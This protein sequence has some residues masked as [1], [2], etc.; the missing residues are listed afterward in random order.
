M[1]TGYPVIEQTD[2]QVDP[3]KMNDRD[4]SYSWRSSCFPSEPLTISL[5]E[6]KED[7]R[8][9]RCSHRNL[10]NGGRSLVV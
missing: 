1:M 6:V 5:E 4:S 8:G 10:K 9:I 3:A 2:G 7:Q